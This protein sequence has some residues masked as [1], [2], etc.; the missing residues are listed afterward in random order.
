MEGFAG[1]DERFVPWASLPHDPIFALLDHSDCDGEIAVDDLLPLADRL[2]S[3][4]PELGSWADCA[5]RFADGCRTA[6][7]R[8]EP[9]EF[10]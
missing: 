10:R 4:G 3:L 5:T 6:A 1:D 7:S 2:D 9:V 8:G